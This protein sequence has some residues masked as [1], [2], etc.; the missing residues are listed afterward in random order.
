VEE[1]GVSTSSSH[2]ID[3]SA[4]LARAEERRQEAMVLL[5]DL[6]ALERLGSIGRAVL[7]GSVRHGLVVLPDIDIEVAVPE[8]WPGIGF[9]VVGQ[10]ARY[11]TVTRV[12]YAN[13]IADRG[14]VTWEVDVAGPSLAWTLE[15]YLGGPDD[16]YAG[17][18]ET[19]ARAFDA[20][21]DDEQRVAILAIKEVHG[22]D[23][24]YRSIDVYR[25]VCD[26]GIRTVSDYPGWL[27][28]HRAEGLVDWV[29]RGHARDGPGR[30]VTS[31]GG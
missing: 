26:A 7:V 30:G 3:G 31:P 14:W 9:E 27:V 18:S 21:L 10:M 28:E 13:R 4:L 17:W 25:A 1:T 23:D 12:S 20:T 6:A 29:P 11:E 15:I 24:G 5:D 2:V 22:A 16:P 8:L 19:L